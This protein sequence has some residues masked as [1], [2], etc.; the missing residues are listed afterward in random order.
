MK[1]VIIV[2]GVLLAC[3]GLIFFAYDKKIESEV[4]LENEKIDINKYDTAIF[5]GGCFW[6]MEPPF[7]KEEGVI[8]AIS[9]YA[10]GKIKN[11]TYKQVSSGTT[12]HVE[13]VMIV[14]DKSK[15]SY[16]ELLAI[17]WR[18]VDPTDDKGQFVDRGKQY[19]TAIFYKTK[20]EKVLAEESKEALEALGLYDEPIIT[21][22]IKETTFYEAEKY[23]QDYYLKNSA[24]YKF[25]RSGSGRDKFLDKIWKDEK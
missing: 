11:P 22:I 12:E 20:E 24:K 15:I 21:P 6:C 14:Y 4:I 7:E 9:G 17:F 2:A 10:G 18:Q 19:T 8:E 5:A 1:K 13:A 25:Y 23:H 3:I 16:E